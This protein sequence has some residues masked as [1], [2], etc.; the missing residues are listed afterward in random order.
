MRLLSL[1]CGCAYYKN[2]ISDCRCEYFS[3]LRYIIC[4]RSPSKFTLTCEVRLDI[5]IIS[6]SN[7]SDKF[8]VFPFD[9]NGPKW[10]ISYQFEPVMSSDDEDFEEDIDLPTNLDHRLSNTS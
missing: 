8:R 5:L 6:E 4:F 1:N 9:H 7:S 10:R 2:K 3:Q